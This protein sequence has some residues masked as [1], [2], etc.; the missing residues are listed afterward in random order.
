MHQTCGST[1]HLVFF[2]PNGNLFLNFLNLGILVAG[3]LSAFSIYLQ[4][5]R[6]YKEGEKSEKEQNN[7]SSGEPSHEWKT[8]H[9]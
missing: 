3:V 4:V 5:Y 2:A 9:S 8:I 6:P 1:S 7:K